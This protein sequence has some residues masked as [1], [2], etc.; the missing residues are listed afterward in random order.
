MAS[1]PA[2]R[3]STSANGSFCAPSRTRPL[4]PTQIAPDFSTTGNKAAA[5]P[6]VMGSLALPRETRFETTTRF[7]GSP[8]DGA[9]VLTAIHQYGSQPTFQRNETKF[10]PGPGE[11]GAFYRKNPIPHLICQQHCGFRD[12]VDAHF[13]RQQKK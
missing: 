6:P 4:E 13:S 7:T 12:A 1:A 8:P 9:R 2:P 3:A 10:G 5:S 11:S